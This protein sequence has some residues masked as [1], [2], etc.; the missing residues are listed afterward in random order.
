MASYEEC[1][2]DE[3]VSDMFDLE[4]QISSVSSRFPPQ[5]GSVQVISSRVG[6]A[7]LN[8]RNYHGSIAHL[9]GG[10]FLVC[11]SILDVGR[12]TDIFQGKHLPSGNLW[13]NLALSSEPCEDM[14]FKR[15]T[16][17]SVASVAVELAGTL[18]RRILDSPI[19][20]DV[21]SDT[22]TPGR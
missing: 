19:A 21:C 14:A 7:N 20:T 6:K 12:R 4:E 8:E 18:S 2:E 22:S 9:G 16:Y 3:Q 5:C 15:S 11:G 10:A 1:E 13:L 17:G